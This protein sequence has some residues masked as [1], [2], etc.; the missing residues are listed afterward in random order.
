MEISW[1][2]EIFDEIFKHHHIETSHL[3]T[4]SFQVE[5]ITI[6]KYHNLKP[7]CNRLLKYKSE[8]TLR[9]QI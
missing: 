9:Y 7:P 3:L 5:A 1:R 6:N 4:I 2:G 8:V